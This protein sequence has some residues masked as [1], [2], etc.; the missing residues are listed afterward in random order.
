MTTTATLSITGPDDQC[1]KETPRQF[2]VTLSHAVD[3]DVSVAWSAPQ[4]GDEAE[5]GDLGSTSGTVTFGANSAAGAA[6]T[7]TV[8]AVDDM[9]SEG[10]ETFTVTLGTITVGPVGP[11]V[12]GHLHRHGDHRRERPDYRGDQTARPSVAEGA[13]PAT[14]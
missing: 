6:R 9:L 12:G 3:A 13:R 1:Q 4:T 7:I 2:T 14:R 10:E 11:G 5:A 8:G